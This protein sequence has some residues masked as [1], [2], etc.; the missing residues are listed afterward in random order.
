MYSTLSNNETLPSF[1]KKHLASHNNSVSELD[2]SI[3][4]LITLLPL[5]VGLNPAKINP[6]SSMLAFIL[7]RLRGSSDYLSLL[8]SKKLAI[9]EE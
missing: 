6:I 3:S 2:E 1:I 8:A 4:C 9:S 7:T 5:V